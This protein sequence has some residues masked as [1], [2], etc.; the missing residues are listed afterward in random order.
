MIDDAT[1]RNVRD[2]FDVIEEA[3][4]FMLAYAAQGRRREG[5]DGAGPSQIRRFLQR[6]RS[7]T[8][9][10]TSLLEG[11]PDDDAGGAFR[12]RWLTDIQAVQ[13]VIDMLLAQPSIT[14]EMIDNT[15]GLIV[16]RSLL[17]ELF[18]ADQVMLPKR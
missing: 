5:A 12:E 14:S 7:A 4:E 10:L 8:E 11:I 3:Y 2:A 17:T 16:M 13:S 15:N 1:A 9:S 18:F 6:F